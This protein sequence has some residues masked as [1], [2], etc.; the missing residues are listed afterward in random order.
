MKIE[1]RNAVAEL[2]KKSAKIEKIYIETGLNNPESKRL[3]EEIK[4][5]GVRVQFLPKTAMD[6]ESETHRHQGFIA[7]TEDYKYVDLADV[8][9]GAKDK[10]G[11][12]VALDGISDPHN[13]GSI[14]RV[15]ECAGADGLIITKDRCCP[16][17]ETV[18]RVSEG[19]TS[20][21]K[22]ARVTNLTVALNKLKDNG[23]WITGAEIGGENL[24]DADLTGK[25]VIVIGGE[26]T[27]IRRLTK[28]TCDRIVTIPMQGKVNSL[29]ASVACAVV[30]FEAQRQRRG[31]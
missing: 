4:N 14:I 15:L 29:N 26:D 25:T 1:G 2:V 24:Y 12:I 20:Y 8:I 13:L 6:K 30:V 9:D 23:Y 19:G 28:D 22:I 17:N 18:I 10:D 5:R 31:K 3:V 16:V 7:V 27:G 11:L 21:V